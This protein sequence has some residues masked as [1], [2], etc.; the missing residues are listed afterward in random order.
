MIE[1]V[2][3]FDS[4]SSNRNASQSPFFYPRYPG[5]EEFQS[6]FPLRGIEGGPHIIEGQFGQ[7]VKQHPGDHLG[8]MSV[9]GGFKEVAQL[10]A[11]RQVFLGAVNG[12][13]PEAV[14]GEL[15]M[16]IG[17]RIVRKPPLRRTGFGR[18]LPEFSV[19]PAEKPPCLGA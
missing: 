4:L 8:K 14:P 5:L 13:H 19:W 7:D 18:P 17:L 9:V 3:F 1:E 16:L 11:G 2:T 6:H 15:F 12:I 10:V